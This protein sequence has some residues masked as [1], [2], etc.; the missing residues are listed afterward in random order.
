VS[1]RGIDDSSAYLTPPTGGGPD[2]WTQTT[3]AA[4]QV[5]TNELL[6]V[7]EIAA[8]DAVAEALRLTV[9]EMVVVRRRLILIGGRPV[10][11][12]V[13]HYPALI[14]AGTALAEPRKIRGGAP[15]VLLDLGYSADYADETLELESAATD[16]EAALLKVDAGARIVRMF[17]VAFTAIGDPF[18]VATAAM[19]PTGRTLR[20]RILVG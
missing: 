19:L 16:A 1:A 17:R 9:G 5:G 6:D 13:S 8:P 10:E 18:E 12:A 2:A 7:A 3:A 11:L 4:G 14:A 15:R 20:H